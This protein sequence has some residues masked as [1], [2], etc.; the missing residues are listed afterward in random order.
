MADS[1]TP[2]LACT[3]SAAPDRHP[4]K[5][6]GQ[7]ARHPFAVR[8]PASTARAHA[9]TRAVEPIIYR[10]G[11]QAVA[12]SAP[13]ANSKRSRPACL[14]AYIAMS[15]RSIALVVVGSSPNGVTPTDAVTPVT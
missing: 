9:S 13:G 12:G 10:A 4:T 1:A 15:A 5:G 3:R 8:R 6:A 11:P 2:A 7:P 14:A